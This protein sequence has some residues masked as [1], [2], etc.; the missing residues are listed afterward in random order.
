MTVVPDKQP[1]RAFHRVPDEVEPLTKDEIRNG[2]TLE[3]KARYFAER[4]KANDGVIGRD[5]EYRPRQR[6]QC[7]NSH[8]NPVRRFR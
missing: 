7:A 2:W 3:S 1:S 6:P 8:Y 5:P 4:K